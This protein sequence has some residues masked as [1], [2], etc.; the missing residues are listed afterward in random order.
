MLYLLIDKELD[1]IIDFSYEIRS[2]QLKERVLINKSFTPIN[3]DII[4]VKEE[5]K[6]ASKEY[7]Q[8]IEV[9]KCDTRYPDRIIEEKVVANFPLNTYGKKL[10]EAVKN[11]LTT[12]TVS[13]MYFRIAIIT[14]DD[15]H[16]RYY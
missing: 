6:F 4:E 5:N 3:L 7:Y 12:I 1:T 2:L 8:L 16:R 14:K 15:D 11:Y 10:A 13:T 9:C